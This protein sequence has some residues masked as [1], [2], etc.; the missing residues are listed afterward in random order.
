MSVAYGSCG[1]TD[2]VPIE[3]R[4]AAQLCAGTNDPGTDFSDSAPRKFNG[5]FVPSD[6]AT[7][8]MFAH[9]IAMYGK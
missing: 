6:L 7:R 1:S 9:W 5:F 4:S 2:S 8:S 3:L